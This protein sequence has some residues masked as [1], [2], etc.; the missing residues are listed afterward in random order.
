MSHER[1]PIAEYKRLTARF[2]PDNLNVADWVAFARNTGMK[3]AC[4]TTRHHEG[5]A[6]FDTATTDFNAQRVCGRDLVREFVEACRAG[7]LRPCLYYSVGDWGDPGYKA[8]PRTDPAGWKRFVEVVHA[9]LR[10]LMTN[11]GEIDY[12][13]YDLCPPPET[14]AAA[15]LHAEL[16]RLQPNLLIS[17]RC[18]LDEDVASSESHVA[19]HGGRFWECCM[20][21]GSN[22]GYS[23]GNAGWRT[24][25]QTIGDLLSSVHNGGNFLLNIGPKGDGTIVDE[26]LRVFEQFGD[27]LNRNREMVFGTAPHPFTFADQKLSTSRG[28]TAYVPLHCYYGPDT[29]VAGIG[30]IVRQVRLLANGQSVAF[31]QDGNH[32]RLTGLPA[33]APDPYHPVLAFELDGPP[34]GVPNPLS[35]VT[36]FE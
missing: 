20:T 33:T 15:E 13:F 36:R 28:N 9:Q 7:G 32:V 18:G 1:I 31:T 30:N 10:E 29:V 22:W 16:R 4:L 34:R 14:W 6:L 11:Y 2:R 19:A 24:A 12:L 25:R 26:E 3:Y 5:F 21:L 35:D 27:W 23:T 17:D 8:G